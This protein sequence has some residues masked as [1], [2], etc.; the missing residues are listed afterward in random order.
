MAPP[1]RPK[2]ITPNRLAR[3]GKPTNKELKKAPGKIYHNKENLA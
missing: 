2:L 1:R 3:K